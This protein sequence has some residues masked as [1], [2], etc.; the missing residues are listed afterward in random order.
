[1]E[2]RKAESSD[3]GAIL[4]IIMP[5]IRE[6]ATYALDPAMGEAEALAYWLGADRETF[7]AVDADGSLLGSYYLRQNQPGG[8]AHVSN[9]GYM[10][11]ATA[12]GRGVARRMCAH[13]LQLAQQRGYRAMQFNFVV[14]TNVGAI[15]LWQKL[16]FVVV[17]RLPGAFA[18]P[19]AGYV[20]ALVMFRSLEH[21]AAC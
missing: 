15:A 4:G 16:G 5:V 3:A 18:H 8:G 9:C 2:I 21:G 11:A 6:G 20:D 10:T 1:M 13:S 12:R 19:A 14:S 7:V 17:G